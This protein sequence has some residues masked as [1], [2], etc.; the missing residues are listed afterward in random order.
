MVKLAHTIELT[1]RVK[2]AHTKHNFLLQQISIVV[3]DSSPYVILRSKPSIV[4]KYRII[5][6]NPSFQVIHRR[7]NTH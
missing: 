3:S 5:A 4:V 1:N 2:H 7:K 6:G